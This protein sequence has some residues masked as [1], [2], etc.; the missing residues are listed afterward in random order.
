MQRVSAF[1]PSWDRRTSNNTASSAQSNSAT[2][3]PNN[4]SASSLGQHKTAASSSGFFGWSNRSSTSSARASSLFNGL[5]KINVQNAN[6]RNSN[7]GSVANVRVQR[8]AFW[9][10]TLDAECDKA[11][12][13]IKSFCADGY[14]ATLNETTSDASTTEPS[15]PVKVPKKIPKRIIQN[16]AG[17]AV[18]TCMRSGLWMTGSGGSGILIARKSDGTWSPPT[19]I[20]LHTP[21]LSFIIGVDVY[22]CVLVVNSLAALESM[23]QS[24]VVLGEDVG[25]TAG[26]LV[27]LDKPGTDL[28]I[29]LKSLGNTV[30]TYMKARGQEQRV[31]MSG[32]ILTERTNENER[33]Y[34]CNASQMDILSGSIARHVEETR[35]LS[36]VIKLAEGR[37]D[38]DPALIAKLMVDPAP[39]DANIASPNSTPQSP[40]PAQAFGVPQVDD[41][42]PFGVLALEMAGME[43]REAGSRLR[44]T[45][46]Q[47]NF[48]TRP[49]S[50]ASSR[51]NFRQS[52]QTFKS[53]TQRESYMSSRTIRSQVTDA[54]T[55]TDV[56]STPDTSPSPGRSEQDRGRSPTQ[57]IRSKI[58]DKH[59]EAQEPAEVDYTTV[60]ETP[61][62][63]LSSPPAHTDDEPSWEG[64]ATPE[65]E[66]DGSNLR[67]PQ[68]DKDVDRRSKGSSHYG[69]EQ[70][71]PAGSDAEDLSDEDVD[72]SDEEEPVVFEVA[73]VQPA[74]TQAVASRVVHARGN[75]VNIPKRIPPPLPVR[76]PARASM[77]SRS[78]LGTDS[79]SL[80][81]PLRHQFS[82]SD[83]SADNDVESIDKKRAPMQT[84][85]ESVASRLQTPPP[86]DCEPITP[87]VKDTEHALP[88]VE[89][90][91]PDSGV[92]QAEE[93]AKPIVEDSKASQKAD[94][95]VESNDQ[96]QPQSSSR[97]IT[98]DQNKDATV[99]QNTPQEESAEDIESG[100]TVPSASPELPSNNEEEVSEA[101]VTITPPASAPKGDGDEKKDRSSIDTG[102]S[103]SHSSFED[104]VY[105]TPPTSE[106]KFPL[107]DDQDETPR[108]TTA[109]TEDVAVA[110]GNEVKE[111]D[112]PASAETTKP[113][114]EQAEAKTE[115]PAAA[116]TSTS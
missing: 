115:I 90:L 25:L 75:M 22:D 112:R 1:L 108:K 70:D 58:E 57:R 66:K 55:Q 87:R 106:H 50:A 111:D 114:E 39:G 99:T 113:V 80:R 79:A 28:E 3:D 46:S 104:G 103:D 15:T 48:Q 41:P 110:Y 71:L 52:S 98:D 89:T 102:V 97:E 73:A 107:D 96:D 51:T 116:P 43:I 6:Q 68:N 21:T 93:A 31:N 19:G 38:F 36:E 4:A 24:R 67:V 12:R 33:F 60:D 94:V 13:I 53:N 83:L 88:L 32:C 40:R 74:R 42:D 29:D 81:S 2:K 54:H 30:L 8:E 72:S 78:D 86:E 64:V 109:Q 69:E 77:Q 100:H 49:M 23:T 61:L 35:P 62:K 56:N 16:A 92:E 37:S 9:P 7:T 82:G 76:N 63:H 14:L 34:G 20:M 11:A 5:S 17:I 65:K 84:Q 44:P 47:L 10:A 91:Q 85:N 26:P 95:A 101:V 59:D 18:F 45:S 27:P 105:T